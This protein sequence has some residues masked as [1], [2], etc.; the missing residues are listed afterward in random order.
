[1]YAKLLVLF[2]NSQLKDKKV[3][4]II[5]EKKLLN[6]FCFGIVKLYI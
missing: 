4:R 2:K 1:M 3:K 6:Q 5:L